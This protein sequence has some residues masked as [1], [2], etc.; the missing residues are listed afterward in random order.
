MRKRVFFGAA[1]GASILILAGCGGAGSTGSV[2]NETVSADSKTTKEQTDAVMSE[3]TATV[4]GAKTNEAEQSNAVNSSETTSENNKNEE[5]VVE[6][7][8]GEVI[9]EYTLLVNSIP[10]GFNKTGEYTYQSNTA[11]FTYTVL[12]NISNREAKSKLDNEAINLS[13]V[14]MGKAG[15]AIYVLGKKDG[16]NFM[17]AYKRIGVGDGTEAY[18]GIEYVSDE[19]ISESDVAA[20]LEEDYI[21]VKR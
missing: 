14:D 7:N 21:S 12:G 17:T 18:V 1:I 11:H 20:Y 8:P 19:A 10:D 5:Q 13:D 2:E 6:K 15:D 16:H 4:S 3:N 9:E